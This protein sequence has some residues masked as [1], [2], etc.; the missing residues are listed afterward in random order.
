MKIVKEATLNLATAEYIWVADVLYNFKSIVKE[1]T[2]SS[3]YNK[4]CIAICI[5]EK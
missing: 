1:Y 2:G 5:V 4:R 3:R